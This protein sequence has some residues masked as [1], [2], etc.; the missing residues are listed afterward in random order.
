VAKLRATDSAG[1]RLLFR[2]EL[3]AGSHSGSS[4]RRARIEDE[5]GVQAFVL[6]A[7]GIS[8]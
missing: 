7:M 6:D 2:A 8:G 3:G 4:G 5:A 1:S